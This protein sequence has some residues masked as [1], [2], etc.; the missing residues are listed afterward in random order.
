MSKRILFTGGGSA[1]HVT[2]NVALI[3]RFVELGWDVSYI[4]SMKGIESELIKNID[5]VDYY[6][7]STGKLRRYMSIE[8]FKDPFRIVKGVFEAYNLIRKIKPD[9]VFSKGGFVSVPVVIGAK[10]NKVPI[11]IHESDITPGLANRISLPLATNICV[12]FPETLDHIKSDKATYVGAIIREELRSGNASQGL[13]L[14]QFVNNKPIIL[15]MGG[16]LGSKKINGTI[17]NNLPKLLAQYQVVHICGK[18]QLDPSIHLDGYQQ[19]EYIHDELPNVIASADIVVTRAGS[20]SIFEFLALHKPMLLIPLSRAAS[21][22]DQILN[23]ESFQKAGFAEVL[24][25]EDLTDESFIQS[26]ESLISRRDQMTETMAR[27]DQASTIDQ[28]IELI[29]KAAHKK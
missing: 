29:Q 5:S 16:S 17:R 20:N 7:I 11:I 1:G 23:A 10:L 13:E 15:V 21:R 6:G 14:L 19:F 27:Q 3:P 4:G 25:E 8:N 9:V 2:V 18:G 12:T 26:L 24:M 28:V 22:G